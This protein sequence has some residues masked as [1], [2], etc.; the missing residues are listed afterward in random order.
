MKITYFLVVAPPLY[1]LILK[2][3][4]ELEKRGKNV[5]ANA[6][7]DWVTSHSRPGLSLSNTKNEVGRICMIYGSEVMRTRARNAS[8]SA[9]R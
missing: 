5:F 3:Q 1:S 2:P 6:K 4:P 7:K 9:N 8:T